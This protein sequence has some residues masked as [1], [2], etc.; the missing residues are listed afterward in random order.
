MKALGAS[1]VAISGAEQYMALQRGT[2]DGTDFPW[3]TMEQYK[4]HEVLD[5][6]I[7]PALHTPGVVEVIVNTKAYKALKPEQQAALMQAA[8]AAM[9]KSFA[10]GEELDRQALENSSKHGVKV[11]TITDA[12]MKRFRAACAPL[13]DSE[14]KKSPASARLVQI[15][16]DHLKSKG[17][18]N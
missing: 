10:A 11:V 7:K 2:V 4:F 8:K 17:I 5:H 1:A 13:W 12:E 15:L 9:E 18:E 6:I 16:K 3:Y 14:A